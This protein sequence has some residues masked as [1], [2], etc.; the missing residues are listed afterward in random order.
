MKS[1]STKLGYSED[2]DGNV[3]LTLTQDDYLFLLFVLGGAT[4]SAMKKSDVKSVKK[5]IELINR[6]NVGNSNYKPY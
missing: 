5:I 1:P 2:I 4:G 6:I 3:I